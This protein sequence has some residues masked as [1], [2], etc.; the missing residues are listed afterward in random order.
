MAYHSYVHH[1]LSR[2]RRASLLS[3]ILLLWALLAGSQAQVKS[4]IT[5]DGTLGTAVSPRGTPRGTFFDR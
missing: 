2:L 5:S 4:A 1:G 3:G